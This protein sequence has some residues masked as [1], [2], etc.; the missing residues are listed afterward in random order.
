MRQSMTTA[1]CA[2]G[3]AGVAV[4]SP[5][6]SRAQDSALVLAERLKDGTDEIARAAWLAF[7]QTGPG[8]RLSIVNGS[9]ALSVAL[10][11][12]P[13]DER[14]SN[15]KRRARAFPHELAAIDRFLKGQVQGDREPGQL[16]LLRSF[17]KI[18]DDRINRSSAVHIAVVGRPVQA[19]ID[20]DYGMEREDGALAVPSDA[21][22]PVSVGENPYGTKERIG[23]LTGIFVHLCHT[24][25]AGRKVAA[26]NRLRRFWALWL[27]AQGGTLVTWSA[28]QQACLQRFRERVEEP[29]GTT[30]L[31]PSVPAAM[32]YTRA[33]AVTVGSDGAGGQKTL[34]PETYNMFLKAPHPDRRDII[35]YTGVE[36]AAEDFPHRYREAWCYFHLSDANG[37]QVRV[38]VGERR[39]GRKPVWDSP[40]RKA[41]RSVRLSRDDYLASKTA[42]RFPDN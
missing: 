15:I 27:A 30:P 28:D 36:Y 22:I 8:Q 10:I 26:R 3:L 14:L 16:D 42:C 18:G 31:D 2:L 12:V 20:P 9:T 38:T 21:L 6:V 39:P 1:L 23:N 33:A 25:I 5:S 35:V 40:D 24:G 4:I 7:E 29:V 17:H 37:A 11:A 13:N 41:L 32:I 34:H 19:T